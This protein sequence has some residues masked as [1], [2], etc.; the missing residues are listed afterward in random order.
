MNSKTKIINIVGGPSVGKSIIASGVFSKLKQQ[1][2]NCE[3]VSEFPKEMVWEGN[4]EILENQIFVFAEQFRRQFR[5]LNKVD[6]V[7]TDSPL[8]LQ[9]VYLIR[10]SNEFFSPK[11]IS[12]TKL[13]MDATFKE[14]NNISFYIERDSTIEFEKTGRK[15]SLEESQI[16]DREIRNQLRTFDPDY[17]ICEGDSAGIIDEI[18]TCLLDDFGK[19]SYV[20]I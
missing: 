12:Q 15:H 4:T 17:F 19:R 8:I 1:K 9:S 18:V 6:F 3:L 10:A 16:L 13:F 5:L 7:I 14:F 20:K 11:Y 2:Q